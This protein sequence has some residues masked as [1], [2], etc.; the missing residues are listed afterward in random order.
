VGIVEGEAEL[1]EFGLIKL[2]HL[3]GG[4]L[5]RVEI[6]TRDPVV[7]NH[8]RLQICDLLAPLEFV[9]VF[10]G[11]NLGQFLVHVV[12]AAHHCLRPSTLIMTRCPRGCFPRAVPDYARPRRSPRRASTSCAA[13]SGIR[14]RRSMA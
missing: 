14:A 11:R 4:I 9:G 10:L 3:A 2:K 5:V 1:V 8:E 6:R 12:C 7:R 13:Q